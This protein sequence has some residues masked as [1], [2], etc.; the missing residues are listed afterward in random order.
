M[1]T[2]TITLP[3]DRL[4][5]LK[6]RATRYNVSPEELV[7]VSID[8]QERILLQV[9]SGELERAE[10]TEWLRGHIVKRNE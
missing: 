4:T 2:I 7:R 6:E 1:E 3:A 10:F 5:Q 9:A 8:E